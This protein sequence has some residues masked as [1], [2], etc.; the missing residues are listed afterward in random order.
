MTKAEIIRKISATTNTTKT[1]CE[2]IIDSFINEIKNGLVNGE[3]VIIKGFASF[4]VCERPAGSR[5]NPQTGKVENY[6]STKRV[7]CR[8]SKAIKEIINKN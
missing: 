6:S 3:R 7:R 1:E 8:I 4:D 2:T 5:R